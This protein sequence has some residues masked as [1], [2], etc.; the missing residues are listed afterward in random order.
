MALSKFAWQL[1]CESREGKAAIQRTVL[2]HAAQFAV[3]RGDSPFDCEC[4]TAVPDENGEFH[5]DG[6]TVVDLHD[7]IGNHCDLTPAGTLDDAEAL[8]QSIL[9]DGLEWILEDA[10]GRYAIQYGGAQ[11][12][13][14]V[15]EQVIASIAGLTAGLHQAMPESYFPYLFARR[16]DTLTRICAR[17]DIDVPEIP[18]KL[19]KRERALY[20]VALNRRF[21]EFRK[22][23]GMSPSEL[24]SFLYDFAPKDLGDYEQGPLPAPTRTWFVMG[25]IGGNGDFEFLDKADATSISHWQGNL[26]TRRGDTIIMWCVAPRSCVHS[27]WRAT[28]D[29]FIDPYF[30]FYSMIRVGHPI[31]VPTTKF[32]ELKQHP[33]FGQHP[34]VRAHFQ[35]RNGMS[36]TVGEYQTLVRMFGEKGMDVSQLPP[37]PAE[38]QIPD[39]SLNDERDVELHLVEPLL[40]RLGFTASDWRYQ[41]RVRMGRGERNVPDYVLGVDDTPGEELG[42]ALIECKYDIASAKERKEAFIQGKSYALRLT[43]SVFALAARQG[44]WLYEMTSRG[45]DED[46]HLYKS[47]S[48]L[49]SPDKLAEIDRLIGKRKINASVAERERR[50][51]KPYT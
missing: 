8:F 5:F 12:I 7:L 42:V 19:Q 49:A 1:Y 45:F 22:S 25:G 30:Y 48:E 14:G 41:L 47:W 6:Q 20:Y 46:Q 15:E 50:K 44:L 21:Q 36:F 27:V 51:R 26:E 24:N 17:Y 28:D 43:A 39:A 38:M 29:A 2:E 10:D 13:D 23:M 3:E 18:G 37:P 9:D 35:G 16:F 11:S 33:V 32:A 31:R 40:R 34:A 4:L